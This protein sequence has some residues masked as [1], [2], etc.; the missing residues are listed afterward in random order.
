[1]LDPIPILRQF[2]LRAGGIVRFAPIGIGHINDKFVASF[3][4]LGGQP[5]RFVLQRINQEVFTDVDALM[6]NLRRVTSHLGSANAGS[7]RPVLSLVETVDGNFYHR[8]P[9]GGCW[10][11]FPF[12]GETVTYKV[13]SSPA[14]VEQL[15][16]AFGEFSR[17]LADLPGP[18]LDEVIPDFHNS[19]KRY[20]DFIANVDSDP[21]RRAAGVAAEIGAVLEC[22]SWATIISDA[23]V[24]GDVPPRVAHNDSKVENVLFDARTGAPVC[25]VD[26]DTVMPGSILH[27]F[28]D[29]VR[30]AVSTVI[31]LSSTG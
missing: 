3:R 7:G 8:D 18:P 30:S 5:V 29:L 20:A 10:R 22:S 27:D 6:Q 11:V 17:L 4:K 28:G 19:P 12:I 13:L 14:Q 23:Q 31:S 9:G 15:G 16:S 1:M 26:L 2:D 21:A 24:A 25:V